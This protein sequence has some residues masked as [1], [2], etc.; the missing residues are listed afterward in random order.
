MLT[1]CVKIVHEKMQEGKRENE[2]ERQ[3]SRRVG[4]KRTGT[5][6]GLVLIGAILNQNSTAWKSLN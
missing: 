4:H 5:K 1:I 3:T 2:K 6:E